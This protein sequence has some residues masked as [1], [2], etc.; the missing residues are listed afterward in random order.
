MDSISN[1][2]KGKTMPDG[3]TNPPPADNP[4]A[5]QPPANQPPAQPPRQPVV[6][7]SVPDGLNDT[8]AQITTALRGLPEN[9]ANAAREAMTAVSQPQSGD[10]STPPASGG[11]T[12]PANPAS[13]SAGTGGAQQ[14]PERAPDGSR[15]A[16]GPSKFAQWWFR[17]PS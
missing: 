1:P 4:P 7:N 10:E 11:S 14:P 5:N 3:E 6:V 17:M 8:L 15:G 12:P 9:V 16:G 13:G 2:A